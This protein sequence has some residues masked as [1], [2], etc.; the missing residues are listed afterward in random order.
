INLNIYL[1]NF[2]KGDF[3]VVKKYN[4]VSEKM[5]K[6]LHG[7]DYNPEQWEKYPEI[8]DEDMRLMKLANCNVVSIDMFYWSK[9]EPEERKFTFGWL[10]NVLDKLSENDI[11]AFLAT[12]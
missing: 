11:F 5:P 8:L 4:P 7:A 9:L 1:D 2:L 6:M 12:P 10:D 3:E